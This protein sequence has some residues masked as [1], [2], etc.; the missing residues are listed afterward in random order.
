MFAYRFFYRHAKLRYSHET[1]NNFGDL[2]YLCPINFLSYFK[3]MCTMSKSRSYDLD[4]LKVFLTVMVIFHHAGQAYGDG[5]DWPYHPSNPV[6]YMPEI[7]RFFSTNAAYLMGLFFLI[8]GYFVP[9][10]FDKQGFA[11]FMRKKLVRLGIP[12]AIVT[13][14][15]TLMVGQLEMGTMWYVETLLCFCL[16]YGLIRCCGVR[17]SETPRF[18]WSLGMLVGIALVMGVG[19][20]CIRQFSPQD[21][22]IWLLGV[23]RVEPAHWLQYVMMFSLGV[24]LSRWKGLGSLTDRMGAISLGIGLVFVCFNVIRTGALH[25]CIQSYFGLFESF[26]CLFLSVGLLWLFRKVAKGTNAFLRWCSG[27]AYGAYVFHLF[28]LLM[29]Q[30]LL[31]GLVLDVHVKFLLIGFLAT[32]M[33]FGF[34]WLLK[35]LPGVKRVL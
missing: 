15:L 20:H 33:S 12:L 10:S 21:H 7:W 27:Q 28:I 25:D 32:L 23:I 3:F 17:F 2:S 4:N 13:A 18:S 8:S 30:N 26:L 22:W 9:I 35:L 14:L 11:T 6:E 1:T 5:G 24:L 16:A 19:S 31:D 29:L 34:T